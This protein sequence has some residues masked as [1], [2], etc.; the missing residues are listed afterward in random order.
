M[1]R[2]KKCTMGER[3]ALLLGKA[4]RLC[5]IGIGGVGM[6]ALA[7]IC[8]SRGIFVFGA[9]AKENDHTRKLQAL[10]IRVLSPVVGDA[11]DQA[12][13]VVCSLAIPEE[14]PDVVR[15]RALHLPIFTRGELLGALMAESTASVAVSGSHG[16]STVTAML[17]TV[18]LAAEKNPTV[19]AGALL[20]QTGESYRI[21][22]SDVFLAEACEYGDS[23]LSLRPSLSLFLNLEWDHPDYF[24]SEA[25]LMRSF[26][27]AADQSGVVIYSAESPLLSQMVE[28]YGIRNAISVGMNKDCDFQYEIVAYENARATIRFLEKNEDPVLVPLSVEGRFQAQNAAMA[29]AAAR[30]LALPMPIA[31]PALSAFSGI[32]RRLSCLFSHAERPIYYDYAHHPT[33]IRAGIEALRDMYH[34]PI[35]VV[36]RPHTFSRTVAL[37]SDFAAALRLA[38]RAIVTDIDGARERGDEALAEKLSEAAGGTYLPL[39][40]VAAAVSRAK[41]GPVVLM[42]AGD[43]SAVLSKLSFSEQKDEKGG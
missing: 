9:D 36:F 8:A 22:G 13:A 2:S 42:G 30:Y 17:A 31:A 39:A 21:G 14:H 35:T 11:M 34:A 25:A 1:I 41:S 26:A 27:R 12:T 40:D 37:F 5:F 18:L 20:P 6:Y 23:F 19:A 15:A 3:R 28:M 4:T 7:V 10:G 43:F 16:K 24:P 33:E 38:D 29:L 32:S